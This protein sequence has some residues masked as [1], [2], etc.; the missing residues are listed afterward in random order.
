MPQNNSHTKYEGVTSIRNTTQ[1]PLFRPNM[2]PIVQVTQLGD[3]KHWQVYKEYETLAKHNNLS[4]PTRQVY[5][6]CETQATQ[7]E[8]V[9]ATT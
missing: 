9:L 4:Y 2:N 3:R 8:G 5:K 7:T 6:E 1:K